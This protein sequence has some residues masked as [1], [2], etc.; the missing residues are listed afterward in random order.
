ME[1][2]D[3]QSR[4]MLCLLQ[5]STAPSADPAFTPFV[6]ASIEEIRYAEQL[7]QRIEERYLHRATPSARS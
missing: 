2:P 5:A 7:R 6:T 1:M 3:P 4:E